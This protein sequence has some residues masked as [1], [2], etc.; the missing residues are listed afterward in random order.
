MRW[1]PPPELVHAL[2]TRL[3]GSLRYRA[4]GLDHVREGMRSSPTG[5]V[6]FCL[7]HQSLFAL[8]GAHHGQHVAALASL[9]GDGTIMAEYLARIGLRPV[10]GSSSRGGLKAARE[11]MGAV[12]EGWHAAITVDGPRGPYKEVKPGPFEIARR[13]GAPI[14]PV[15]VRASG[16]ISFKRAWDRFRLP[17]PG[18]RV[19]VVYGEAM[20][21]PA[22]YPTPEDL[23]RRRV[24]L[25]RRLHDLESRAGALVGRPLQGPPRDC[26]RWMR[27]PRG[28]V[29]VE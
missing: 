9:S 1:K 23:A 29:D 7:W 5:S 13:T 21:L 12:T 25:A 22:E 2:G 20:A 19:A 18:A 15:G 11:L 3:A 26:L 10:R 8:L 28:A 24:D 16:E 27:Q 17:L 6:V 14:I 4:V